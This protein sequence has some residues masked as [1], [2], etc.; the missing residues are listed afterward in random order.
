RQLVSSQTQDRQFNGIK[1]DDASI[2]Q[3]RDGGIELGP[4]THHVVQQLMKQRQIGD[5]HDLVPV[6][7]ILEVIVDDLATKL[8][9]DAGYRISAQLP[10]IQPLNRKL[11]GRVTRLAR[12]ARGTA[13]L[14]HAS[15]PKRFINETISMAAMA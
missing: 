13:A 15:P 3:R 8:G 12:I 9:L 11:A 6:F 14:A 2:E 10:L 5:L 7:V 1:V 4:V